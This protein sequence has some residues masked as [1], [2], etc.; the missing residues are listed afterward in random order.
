MLEGIESDFRC[1]L[2]ASRSKCRHWQ[3]SLFIPPHIVVHVSAFLDHINRISR[4]HVG[5]YDQRS[6]TASA[7]L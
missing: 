4:H 6:P 3:Y 1:Q 2:F 7:E 5:P